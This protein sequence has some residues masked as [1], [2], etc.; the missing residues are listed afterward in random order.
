M[1]LCFYR[2]N[3]N[4]C[5]Y[6]P[7]CS[8][9][10]IRPLGLD[11]DRTL[12]VNTFGPHIIY[13]RSGYGRIECNGF[14]TEYSAPSF[15]LVPD[16]DFTVQADLPARG[17]IFGPEL[18][19]LL[20]D[21]LD[22]DYYQPRL[23]TRL[24]QGPVEL[25]GENT[26]VALSQGILTDYL[27]C[28]QYAENKLEEIILTVGPGIQT[29]VENNLKSKYWFFRLRVMDLLASCTSLEEFAFAMGLSG[30][31]FSK[32]FKKAFDRSFYNWYL[33]W[34]LESIA[35]DMI[36]SGLTLS[37]IA[38]KY[39]FYS[40]QHFHHFIRVRTGLPPGKLKAKLISEKQF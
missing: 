24:Q 11:K 26:A 36:R 37:E 9:N 25:V 16:F 39:G 18:V 19:R 32:A 33:D 1:N 29:R 23:G 27:E 21:K 38:G 34:K 12:S 13:L 20:A 2:K 22:V 17:Y 5:R 15:Y 8:E 40:V 31:G 7:K 14:R 30:S 35:D 3:P 4:Y 28:R 10:C 6:Y